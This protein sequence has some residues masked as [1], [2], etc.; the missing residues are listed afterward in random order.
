MDYDTAVTTNKLAT[1]IIANRL[2]YKKISIY[3]LY[4]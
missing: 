3:N 4:L 2:S 1:R